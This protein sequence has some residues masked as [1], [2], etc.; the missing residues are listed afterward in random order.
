MWRII[1]IV[2]AIVGLFIAQSVYDVYL[3]WNYTELEATLI[4]YAE[5]CF[6]EKDRGHGPYFDCGQAPTMT[7]ASGTSD[8]KIEKHAKLLY[9][10]RVPPESQLRQAHTETWAV[11]PGKYWVGQ[12]R[13]I[14]VKKDDPT[15]V[16][17]SRLV[18]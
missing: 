13:N 11:A 2:V 16:L 6:F 7:V 14:S 8:N 9:Q 5:D 15:K 18:V 17:W 12:K 10:Y 1:G 3:S 4:G